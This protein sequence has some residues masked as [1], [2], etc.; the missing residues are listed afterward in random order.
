[1]PTR[2]AISSHIVNFFDNLSVGAQA[3]GIEG[4]KPA[5]TIEGGFAELR[6]KNQ[7]IFA[8][9]TDAFENSDL[10]KTLRERTTANKET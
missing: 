7:E 1:M 6:K 4:I 5:E 9:G 3:A 10:L 8:K 2:Q